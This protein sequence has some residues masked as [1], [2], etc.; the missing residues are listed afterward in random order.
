MRFSNFPVLFRSAVGAL[1]LTGAA[2]AQA[3]APAGAHDHAHHG[4]AT[5]PAPAAAASWAE[6]EVRKLD[7]AQAKVTLR[8][9]PI[10]AL[11]MPGMTMVF[12]A[13]DPALLQGLKEGDKVR[14][15]ADKRQGVYT[16]TAVQPQP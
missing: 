7:Q 16:V 9:G 5:A 1:L 12:R 13:A 11:G 15:Q 6:G 14:F 2:L 8:H 4:Q 10:D 3:Q